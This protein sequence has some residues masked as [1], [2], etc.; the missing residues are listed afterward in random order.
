MA[1]NDPNILTDTSAGDSRPRQGADLLRSR[2]NLLRGKDKLLLTMHI[3]N[4]LSFRQMSQLTGM[5]ATSVSRRIQRAAERLADGKYILCLRNRDRLNNGEMAI[6]KDYFLLGLPMTEI[7]V[8][9]EL[10]Y[11]R[12]RET[13][14]RLRCLVAALGEQDPMT[15]RDSHDCLEEF[16][17]PDL[18]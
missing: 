13:V 5:D 18:R 3:C 2:L 14:K 10:S 1:R 7:A 9:R 8:K 17:S 15:R 12:V 6:A 11:Y 4:G 16:Q